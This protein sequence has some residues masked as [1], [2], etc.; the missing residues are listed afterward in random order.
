MLFVIPACGYTFNASIGSFLGESMASVDN[1]IIH[2]ET[3]RRA[4]WG[5]RLYNEW[6]KALPHEIKTVY[7]RAITPDAE[8][9]WSRM[10]FVRRHDSPELNQY[11][12][13]GIGM[14]KYLHRSS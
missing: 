4:G 1:F 12:N 11:E 13:G 7:L 5:R 9:F 6:E 2:D 14:V 10:G 3:K 8:K